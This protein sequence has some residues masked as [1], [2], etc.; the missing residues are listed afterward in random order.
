[1]LWL[2][3]PSPRAPLRPCCARGDHGGEGGRGGG[4]RSLLWKPWERFAGSTEKQLEPGQG[5]QAPSRLPLRP[6]AR[7]AGSFPG[8]LRAGW[9]LEPETCIYSSGFSENSQRRGN[10]RE[11]RGPRAHGQQVTGCSSRPNFP[12][13]RVCSIIRTRST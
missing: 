3:R 9:G 6:P 10:T 7:G 1:M 2:L 13:G 11:R 4:I 12:A 8:R 5:R